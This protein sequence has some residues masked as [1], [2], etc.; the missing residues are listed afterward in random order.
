VV[1]KVPEHARRMNPAKR[2]DEIDLRFI[3]LPS[4]KRLSRTAKDSIY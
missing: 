2:D 3:G 1:L 4:I